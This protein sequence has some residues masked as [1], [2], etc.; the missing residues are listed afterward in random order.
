MVARFVSDA[1]VLHWMHFAHFDDA[2]HQCVAKLNRNPERQVSQ[3]QMMT[4]HRGQ[5]DAVKTVQATKHWEW[6]QTHR[7]TSQK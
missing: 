1:D 4:M 7:T 5:P 2:R 6:H 3:M